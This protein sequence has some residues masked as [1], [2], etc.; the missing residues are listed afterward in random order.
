MGQAFSQ[1]RAASPSPSPPRHRQPPPPQ[2]QPQ[3]PPPQRAAPTPTPPQRAAAAAGAN[4]PASKRG[5]AGTK[6][7]QP[8]QR[9]VFGAGVRERPLS[10]LPRKYDFVFDFQDAQG[11]PA[12]WRIGAQDADEFAK[13]LNPEDVYGIFFPTHRFK[14]IKVHFPVAGL[15]L[16][17]R[18]IAGTS[19]LNLLRLLR[20][21]QRT[22]DAGYARYLRQP[23]PTEEVVRAAMRGTAVCEI[24]I[25]SNNVY[26][27][28]HPPPPAGP[29]AAALAAARQAGG[30]PPA[31]AAEITSSPPAG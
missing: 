13:G 6:P 28:A 30:G 7:P 10:A 5:A 14:T 12:C 20:Q 21:I 3:P 22:A 16:A 31:A 23:R 8:K 2:P 27:V 26:V 18:K 15:F 24:K 29:L 1:R 19:Y 11:Q 4:K 9:R 25:V 17:T